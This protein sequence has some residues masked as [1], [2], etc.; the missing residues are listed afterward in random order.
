MKTSNYILIA[1]FSFIIGSILVLFIAAIGHENK[2]YGGSYEDVVVQKEYSLEDFSVIVIEPETHIEFNSSEKNSLS[3]F[4]S[5]D[6]EANEK[7]FRISNDTLFTFQTAALDHRQ[8]LVSGN[9]LSAVIVKKGSLFR[10]VRFNS[11]TLSVDLQQAK[12]TVDE[13]EINQLNIQGDKAEIWIHTT[14][15][16]ILSARLKNESTLDIYRNANKIDI[17]KDETSRY[18]LYH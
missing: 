1:F 3:F 5:K 2:S 12:F 15:I 18:S 7:P 4:H 6:V 16:D 13:S 10:A 14:K 8:I 17:E 9:N 11:E